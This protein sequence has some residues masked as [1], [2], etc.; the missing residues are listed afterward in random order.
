MAVELADPGWVRSRLLGCLP[1]YLRVITGSDVTDVELTAVEVP[2]GGQS[3]ET[4]LF[5]VAWTAGAARGHGSFVL[6]LQPQANQMFL[7]PDVLAEGELLRDLARVSAVPVPEVFVLEDD[8]RVLGRPFFLMS[9]VPG[10]IPG[11]RPSIHR[12]PWLIS[13]AEG[14][15]FEAIAAGLRALALVHA[16]DWHRVRR[17]RD[18]AV[19]PRHDLEQLQHWYAWAARGRA[20]PTIEAGIDQL[21]R[22]PARPSG[23]VVLLWGDPRPGNIIFADDGSVAALIDWEMAALGTPASDIGW[24]LMMDDFARR[25]AQGAV[26]EGLPTRSE[27]IEAYRQGGGAELANLEH[28]ELLACVRLAITLIRAAD[29]LIAR[30]IIEPTSRF[31]HENIP[32]QMIADHLGLD[33]PPICDDYRRLSRLRARSPAEPGVLNS[34]GN[35]AQVPRQGT[36]QRTWREKRT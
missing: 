6:R 25:G 15:R 2:R 24:W 14:E 3:N 34:R 19:D 10:H 36:S 21:E 28:F 32:S 1:H 26:L 17:F 13:L 29:S 5:E 9:K 16:T 12:D 27:T 7:D 33:R 20:H 4:V 30:G 35:V 31:V 23:D 11:G 18:A 22:R 8:P